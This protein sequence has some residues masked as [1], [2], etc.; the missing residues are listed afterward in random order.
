MRTPFAR[1]AEGARLPDGNPNTTVTFALTRKL[2]LTTDT[3]GELD[4]VVL[5]C[6]ATSV[7]TTRG[8]LGTASLALADPT[9]ASNV[10]YGPTTV[11]GKRG[12]GF[13]IEDLSQAYSKF[14][15]VAYGARL[16]VA[17]GVN[18]P[19]E[20]TSAVMPLKGIAPALSPGPVIVQFDGTT[21]SNSSYWSQIAPRNTLTSYLDHLGLPY[22]GGTDANTCSIT[23]D[24]LPNIPYHAVSS[25]SEIAAR[26]LHLRGMPFEGAAR[27]FKNMA[28]RAVGTDS[29]DVAF[30][31][32]SATLT[33]YATQQLGV[34]FSPYR[35]GGHESMIIGGTGFTASTQVGTLEL[36]YHVEAVP[37]PQYSLLARPTSALPTVYPTATLDSIL[38]VLHRIPRISFADVVT[39]VGD[40]MLGEIE[41]RAAAGVSGGLSSLAGA[42]ARMAIKAA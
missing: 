37:N 11:T 13:N 33:T 40:A 10:Y 21:A 31:T 26:G 17:S 15:V 25:A 12:A 7:F 19:G 35:V 23:I 32:G 41:G 36:I 6:L 28:F 5:P 4:A 1:A 22:S 38:S 18:S 16:R 2:A 9:T 3:N 27:E 14:R 24:R 34:D 39:S 30:N 20:F 42:L 8:S 29:M